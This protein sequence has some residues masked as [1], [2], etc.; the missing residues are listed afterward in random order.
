[1]AARSQRVTSVSIARPA[2][3]PVERRRG[4]PRAALATGAPLGGFITPPTLLLLR[5]PPL[6]WGGLLPPHGAPYP[7]EGRGPARPDLLFTTGRF[8]GLLLAG[9]TLAVA[10]RRRVYAIPAIAWFLL[11][12]THGPALVHLPHPAP[13]GVGWG[14]VSG[15]AIA[16]PFVW[17]SQWV[18]S[19]I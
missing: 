11:S 15:T 8:C 17:M 19:V 5:A 16:S 7:Q 18:G 1:A 2:G 3:V 4:A 12:M 9:I 10:G 13:I 14:P 6:V